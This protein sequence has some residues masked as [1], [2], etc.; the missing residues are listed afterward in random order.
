MNLS[1]SLGWH[2]TL[3]ARHSEL[4]R[5]RDANSRVSITR[6]GEQTVETKPA[7]D[8]KKLDKRVALLARE[9]RL[10]DEAIK[11]TNAATIVP[12]F[13]RNDEVLGELED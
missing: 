12:G 7:Y 6:F 9:I 8:P 2:K 13:E 10:L 11:K 4:I 1:E 3:T 5:L